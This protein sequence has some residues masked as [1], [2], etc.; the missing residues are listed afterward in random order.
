MKH[1][2]NLK[3][4]VITEMMRVISAAVIEAHRSMPDKDPT[5]LIPLVVNELISHIKDGVHEKA[6]KNL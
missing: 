3:E 4:I 6:A 2:T 1:E 5:E